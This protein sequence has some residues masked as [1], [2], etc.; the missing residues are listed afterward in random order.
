MEK[1]ENIKFAVLGAG[2]GGTAMAA[3]LKKMGVQ[4]RLYDR[5][6]NAIEAIK[7]QKGI[8]LEGRLGNGFYR[9][10]LITNEIS[11]A[12]DGADIIMVVVP[13]FA[14]KYIAEHLAKYI[15]PGQIVVL[16]PGRTGGAL[17]FAQIF[18]SKLEDIYLCEAQTLIYASRKVKPHKTKVYGIKEKVGIASIPSHKIDRVLH[19]LNRFFPQFVK[20]DSVLHTSLRNLGAVFHPAPT[21]LNVGRI[22][23]KKESFDYYIQGISPTIARFLELVDAERIS[24]AK[25]FGVEAPTAAEWLKQ[26]YN[27]EG[28][29]LYEC[30][31]HTRAYMGIKA[32]NKIR[33][34]YVTED[35]PMSL[36]PMIHLG[37]V[38]GI[39]TPNMQLIVELASKLLRKNYWES[40]R[41]LKDMGL[42]GMNIQEIIEFCRG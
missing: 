13:A 7:R 42:E 25:A 6:W 22:E 16:N 20:W 26:T 30:I 32:P 27:S 23:E 19:L 18:G 12:V 1:P 36:V 37:R 35:V 38:A 40:G 24:V 14:H 2:N 29:D 39:E 34:R 11:E 10:D 4:V 31:Q 9:M 3:H 17:E 5:F 28:Y 15:Q 8:F 21:L 33:V 41:T